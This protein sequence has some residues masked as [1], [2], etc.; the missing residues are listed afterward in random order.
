MSRFRL[1]HV[2]LVQLYRFPGVAAACAQA[3]AAA[4]SDSIVLVYH[5][6]SS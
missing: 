6:Q 4:C 5:A 2:G 3:A 1:A